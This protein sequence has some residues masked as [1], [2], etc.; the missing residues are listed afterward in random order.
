MWSSQYRRDRHVGAHP[1]KGH[2]L[3]PRVGHLPC[4][5]RLKDLMFSLQKRRHWG[6]LRAA[7]Q[8]LMEGYKKE[9]VRLFSKVCCGRIRGNYFELKEGRLVL[10]IRKKNYYKGSETL[11]QVALLGALSLETF[12]VR[13]DGALSNLMLLHTSSSFAMNRQ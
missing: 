9:R 11:E 7:F 8:Y 2:K 10:D 1:E 6:E 5:D 3:V 13:L 4:E 12:K